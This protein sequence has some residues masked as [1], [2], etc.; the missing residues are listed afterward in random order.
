VKIDESYAKTFTDCRFCD[1]NWQCQ[2]VSEAALIFGLEF[3]RHSCFSVLTGLLG[4]CSVSIQYGQ[5]QAA[6]DC[7]VPIWIHMSAR[8][9][10][11]GSVLV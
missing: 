9:L 11:I 7:D 8:Q 1:E 3:F 6:R 10:N 2:E 4:K 5:Q